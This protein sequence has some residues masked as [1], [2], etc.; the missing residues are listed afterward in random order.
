MSTPASK[1]S[2]PESARQTEDAPADATTPTRA[3]RTK[4]I[5]NERTFS[6]FKRTLPS[7]NE[8]TFAV[9][10]AVIVGGTY[11]ARQKWLQPPEWVL[12]QEKKKGRGKRDDTMA[13][14]W[15]HEDGLPSKDKVGIIVGLVEDVSGKMLAKVRW[16]ARP[17]ALWSL[18]GP[19]EEYDDLLPVRPVLLLPS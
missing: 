8:V 7:G 14:A 3:S 1:D 15:K 2:W 11:G 16:F 19:D 9:G 4:G 13:N 5:T 10:D 6:S 17:G 18:Q 12:W